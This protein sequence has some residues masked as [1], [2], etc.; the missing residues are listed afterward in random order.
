V[1]LESTPREA[2]RF[3]ARLLIWDPVRES[4]SERFLKNEFFPAEL[5]ERDRDPIN[6]FARPFVW[7]AN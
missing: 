2:P 5:E 1:R 6:V 4:E 7:D 3:S